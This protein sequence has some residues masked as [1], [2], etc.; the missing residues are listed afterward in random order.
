VQPKPKRRLT[1]QLDELW[2]F[3]HDKGNEQ[4]VWFALD[5]ETREIV[6]CYIGAR[7]GASA[8][9][10][11]RCPPSIARVPCVTAISGFRI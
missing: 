2:S 3:V 5:T 1:V 4:W 8:Q 6:G 10:G 7:S 11:S 9:A